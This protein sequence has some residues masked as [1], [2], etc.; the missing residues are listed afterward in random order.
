MRPGSGEVLGF[1]LVSSGHSSESSRTTNHD[2]LKLFLYGL[3]IYGD[4]IKT[5]FK[6]L[7]KLDILL[8]FY[9]QQGKIILIKKNS[10]R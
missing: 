6:F 10:L 9:P 1:T 3:L 5:G 7:F 2:N 8:F 4:Y